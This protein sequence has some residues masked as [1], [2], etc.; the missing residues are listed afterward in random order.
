MKTTPPGIDAT[1]N[2]DASFFAVKRWLIGQCRGYGCMVIVC[3]CQSLRY[4]ASMN[5]IQTKK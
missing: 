5:I 1:A 4:V 2:I 3:G